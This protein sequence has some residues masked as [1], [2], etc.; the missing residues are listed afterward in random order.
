MRPLTGTIYRTLR[1][2]DSVLVEGAL[3]RLQLRDSL[4]PGEKNRMSVRDSAHTSWHVT[5]VP[6][7]A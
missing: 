2:V 7:D 3:D 6:F 5:C 4:S 1:N